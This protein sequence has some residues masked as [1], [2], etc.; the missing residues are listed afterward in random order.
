LTHDDLGGIYLGLAS[1]EEHETTSRNYTHN[2]LTCKT[3]NLQQEEGGTNYK[4][5]SG[6]SYIIK[7]T[8][9]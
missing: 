5:A 4:R 6:I 9:E 3:Q 7:T 2:Y 1:P 8:Y